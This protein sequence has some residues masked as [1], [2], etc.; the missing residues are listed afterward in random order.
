[1]YRFSL[2]PVLRHRKIIEEELQK[3][4][5]VLKRRLISE[6][7]ALLDLEKTKSRCLRELQ[8]KQVRGIRAPEISLYSDFIGRVTIQM[9]SQ[10]KKVL[11]LENTVH[12]KR[13]K[14]VKAMKDRK[15]VDQLK[16]NRLMVF[17][18]NERRKEQKWIDEVAVMRFQKSRQ[19]T[20]K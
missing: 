9:E 3:E 10:Q 19:A 17:E 2:E 7:A 4:M 15:M 16:K 18:K 6:Q 20:S 8:E 1:M 14:L 5:A 11:G 12:K 13:E